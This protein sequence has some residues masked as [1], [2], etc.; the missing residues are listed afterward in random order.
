M[1]AN[2]SSHTRKQVVIFTVGGRRFAI[3]VMQV[4]EVVQPLA[5]EA[6]PG[7]PS[8]IEGLV[9]LR[10]SFLPLV[11]LR[12]RFAT[13]LPSETSRPKMLIVSCRGRA[14][15][16]VVDGVGEVSWLD[17]E[18]LRAPPVESDLGAPGCVQALVESEEGMVML[19]DGERLLSE[20]EFAQLP[21]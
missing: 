7:Q 18:T 6:V 21:Q 12:R 9:Q 8:F 15:A 3:D 17:A 16:F 19:L 5:A 20:T 13:A 4:Q 11:D 1:T 14:L 2:R 10:G